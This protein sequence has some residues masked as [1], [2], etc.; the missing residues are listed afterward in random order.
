M[1]NKNIINLSGLQGINE[2]F[3][4]KNVKNIGEKKKIIY[5]EFKGNMK[6]IKDGKKYIYKYQI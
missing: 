3:I 4:I 2:K 6:Y 1:Q 5:D